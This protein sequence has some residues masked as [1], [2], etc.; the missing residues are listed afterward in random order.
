MESFR[1][2]RIET[3]LI[4]PKTT[5]FLQPLDVLINSSFKAEIKRKWQEWLANGPKEYTNK[6]YRR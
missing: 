2:S 6:G 5:S 4:P 1:N 3:V